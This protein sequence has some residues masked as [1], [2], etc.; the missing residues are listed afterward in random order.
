MKK[1][2]KKWQLILYGCSGLGVNLL[3]TVVA[4]Y[5]GSALL[6]GGF[7]ENVES[8][9]YLNKDLVLAGVW[10]VFV[11]AAKIIDGLIDIPFS[12]LTDN[13]RTKWG[14]RRPAILVG[15]ISTMIVYLLLLVPLNN[16]ATLLNTLWFALLTFAFFSTYTLTMITYYAT[17]AEVTEKQS[18]IVLISNA[19]SICDLIYFALGFALVPVFVNMGVN[20]RI[21]ALACLPLALTMLIP[22]FMLKEKSTLDEG[23]RLPKNQRP[24]IKKAVLFSIKDK[25]FMKWLVC[26]FSMNAGLSLFLSGIN[27]VFS[28][29]GL[30][31]TVIMGTS[32]V[33]IPFTLMLYNRIVRKKGLGFAF[34]YIMIVYSIG[35]LLMPLAYVA[36]KSL[37]YP[38]AIVCALIV[39]LAI[40]A[41]FSISYT[42]PSARAASRVEENKSASSMYFAIQGLAE[43]ISAGLAGGVI[44][45][46]LKQSDNIPWLTVIVA[47]FCMLAC[48]LS[49]TLPKEM[50]LLGKDK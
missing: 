4:S 13:L 33:P 50:T 19:K 17:F 35:M 42:V 1:F 48:G 20:V 11:F 14:K 8:W 25:P 22:I 24:T 38:G 10:A 16:S 18:D 30:N 27:E 6:V 39:S 41:F 37:L 49:F 29:A 36:P 44:L 9:T 31:M 46:W 2:T 12:Y 32:F 23:K 5:L 47:A 21:V 43:G 40:G 7:E 3:N 34:R 28:S 15:L 26:V 45:V